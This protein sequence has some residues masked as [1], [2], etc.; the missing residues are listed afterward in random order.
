MVPLVP[1]VVLGVA[2]W[3]RLCVEFVEMIAW[4]MRS[5]LLE[6]IFPQLFGPTDEPEE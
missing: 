6:G 2:L 3:R 4:K 5:R 1:L